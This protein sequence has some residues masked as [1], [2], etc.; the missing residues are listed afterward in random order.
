LA[1]FSEEVVQEV[2]SR[3]DIVDILSAHLPLKLS[4][5]NYRTLCPFHSEKT[6][7][8]MVSREKQIYHCFGC[9]EGGNVITFLMKYERLSFPEVIRHLANRAG[10]DLPEKRYDGK[11]GSSPK[12]DL[13]EINRLACDFYQAQMKRSPGGVKA[14]DYL[15]AR[16][17]SEDAWN[18]FCMG[19][20]PAS[21]DSLLR[22]LMGKGKPPSLLETAGLI[23][24][25]PRPGEYHDRFRDRLMIPIID[26]QERILGFGARAFA[27]VENKYLN[28]PTSPI[29]SKGETLYGL[30]FAY[31]KIREGGKALIVEGYFD[32]VSLHI[33]GWENAVASSGTSLT[34]GQARLLRRYADQAF[35]LFDSD[36]A[37]IKASARSIEVLLEEGFAVRVAKLPQGH[38]PDSFLRSEGRSGMEDVIGR[39]ADWLDFLWDAAGEERRDRPVGEEVRQV[40]EVLPILAKMK[41]R[42]AAAK[43]LRK[44]SE[45]AGL[46]EE[47]LLQEIKEMGKRSPQPAPSTAAPSRKAFPVEERQVLELALLYPEKR[48]RW[49]QLLDLSEI[50]DSQIREVLGLVFQ[51]GVDDES[52]FRQVLCQGT[53]EEV[54]SLCTRIWAQGR[55]RLEDAEAAFGDCIRRMKERKEKMG[56]RELRRKIREAEETRDFMT[57]D[58]LIKEHPSVKRKHLNNGV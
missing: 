31:K 53:D 13:Y 11:N 15:K 18:R 1:N 26:T 17:V 40:R 55:T 20:A 30:N 38:D 25:G 27:D 5:K 48:D 2:L 54:R 36:P 43:Y 37:G 10:I 47:L 22:H 8:F 51:Y 57:V 9:G 50:S 28:S 45:R 46:K 29:Y 12:L 58:K 52:E 16:G 24:P 44:L 32:L 6:P 35:L 4:G 23:L 49:A 34:S 7:S 21:W 19:Y 41:D 42:L 39:C 14:K 3:T 33:F 56:N